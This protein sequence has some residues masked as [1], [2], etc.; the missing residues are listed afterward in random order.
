M[1]TLE[2]FA[3]QLRER[4]AVRDLDGVAGLI[5]DL[6]R[7]NPAAAA[8]LAEAAVQAHAQL[9]AGADPDEEV[10][11]QLDGFDPSLECRAW[12]PAPRVIGAPSHTHVCREEP[13]H[14]W[15]DED[16][17]HRCTCGHRW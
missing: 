16:S 2:D 6:R 15:R 9:R 8:Q 3:A 1:A 4:I 14:R 13:Q 11:V 12:E 17:E 10:A 7:W 5:A